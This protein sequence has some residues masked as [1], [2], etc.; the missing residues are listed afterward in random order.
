MKEADA[1]RSETVIKKNSLTR[2]L[3]Q[4]SQLLCGWNEGLVFIQ[5]QDQLEF[6]Q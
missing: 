3:K 1:K 6:N 4:K 2:P 5:E